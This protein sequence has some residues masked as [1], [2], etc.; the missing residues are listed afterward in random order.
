MGLG[1]LL[2]HAITG[3]WILGRDFPGSV[4]RAINQAIV[5]SEKMHSAEICFVVESQLSLLSVLGG[6]SAR[7]RAI[8]V[9]AEDRVWDTKRNNGVL[10]YLLLADRDIEFV[11]DRGAAHIETAEIC[12][13]L[14]VACKAGQFGAGVCEAITA[15]GILLSKAFPPKEDDVD[16]V[17]NTIR[18]S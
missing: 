7:D 1:R 15:L 4:M 6:V 14:E 16:E 2:K 12:R 11:L 10:I 17:K 5:E 3:S 13:R 8:E 9:F 18:R